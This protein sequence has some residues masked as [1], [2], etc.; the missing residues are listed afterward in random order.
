MSTQ[1]HGTWRWV[2]QIDR[3]GKEDTTPMPA[4]PNYTFSPDGSAS[5]NAPGGAKLPMRWKIVDGRL[6]IGG[7]RGEKGQSTQ[8]FE[9]PDPNTLVLFDKHDRRGVFERVPDAEQKESWVVKIAGGGKRVDYEDG[10][11]TCRFDA[12][13]QAGGRWLIHAYRW[14]GA[15]GRVHESTG[16][17]QSVI[18]PRVVDYLHMGGWKGRVDVLTEPRV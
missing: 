6:Q 9:M 7:A 15:D 2:K 4:P 16:E 8:R 18:I 3:D 14:T 1:L 11:Q 17:I 5:W 10:K 12:E 13:L